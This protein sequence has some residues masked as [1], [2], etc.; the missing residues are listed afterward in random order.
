M[1]AGLVGGARGKGRRRGERFHG[2]SLSEM[3]TDSLRDGFT[4]L[5][6][7]DRTVRRSPFPMRDDKALFPSFPAKRDTAT[8]GP[9]EMYLQAPTSAA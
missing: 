7:A 6:D 9:C 1:S 5:G 3:L 4:P 8:M 2:P